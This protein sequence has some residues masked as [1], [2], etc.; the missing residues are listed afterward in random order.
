MVAWVTSYILNTDSA[1]ALWPGFMPGMLIL[2]GLGLV[3]FGIWGRKRNRQRTS[4]DGLYLALGVREVNYRGTS[5]IYE[6]EERRASAIKEPRVERHV[7]V[8]MKNCP[9]LP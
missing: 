7:K 8:Q 3:G 6:Q 4:I 9:P 1:G 2:F 5:L